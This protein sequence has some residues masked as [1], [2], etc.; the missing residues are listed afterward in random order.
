[1]MC[2]RRKR[3][4]IRESRD[5]VQDRAPQVHPAHELEILEVLATG[6][7]LKDDL[8]EDG[9]RAWGLERVVQRCKGYAPVTPDIKSG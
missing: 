8:V 2:P 5:E 7:D 4:T 3:R 9:D 6:E 1:M